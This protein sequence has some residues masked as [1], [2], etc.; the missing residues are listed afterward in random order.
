[1]AKHNRFYCI[2]VSCLESGLC[3]FGIELDNCNLFLH[4]QEKV[5]SMKVNIVCANKEI[6]D[7]LVSFNDIIYSEEKV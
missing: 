7:L 4:S 5:L 6:F 2:S 1:M 3:K